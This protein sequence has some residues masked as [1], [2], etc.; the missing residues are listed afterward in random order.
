M[1]VEMPYVSSEQIAEEIKTCLLKQKNI[2]DAANSERM[3]RIAEAKRT[4]SESR[5][6]LDEATA[7]Q[8]NTASR[9]TLFE[10]RLKS[11]I[12]QETILLDAYKAKKAETFPES[13]TLCPTCGQM[14]PADKIDE[15]KKKWET[16]HIATL[17]EDA[18]TGNDLHRKIKALAAD[19]EGE[20]RK[21]KEQA[22]KVKALSEKVEETQKNLEI[23]NKMPISDGSDIPEYNDLQTRI[24]DLRVKYAEAKNIEAQRAEK[25]ELIRQKTE[26]LEAIK[27]E[28]AKAAVNKDID[29]KI[30]ALEDERRQQ[31]D[32]RDKAM[33][34]LDQVS[35]LNMWKNLK[36]SEMINKH[37]SL[38][39][40]DLFE[41]LKNGDTKDCCKPFVY[42]DESGQYRSMTDGSANYSLYL[43]GLIDISDS[44]QK[45]YDT[46]Y[47]I[48]VDSAEAIDNENKKMIKTGC[49]L[50]F[51]T[52]KDGA[53]LELKEIR[54]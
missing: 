41:T 9:I 7:E 29:I 2:L 10:S 54:E 48:F 5:S 24:D 11:M 42:D 36:V 40:F 27:R 32:A 17:N 45:Y 53:S 21:V 3:E 46:S 37:F 19:V 26:E 28:I 18:R 44:L 38:V 20:T 25:A 8:K 33:M 43:R 51:L 30:S 4:F 13:K 1:G 23:I 35:R 15:Y 39:R 50:I 47:P 31:S 34:I 14:L 52:V 6:A 12:E 49:Q 16:I 22:E